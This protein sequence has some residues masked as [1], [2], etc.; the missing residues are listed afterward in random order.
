MPLEQA[1]R[2]ADHPARAAVPRR[3]VIRA[4]IGTWLGAHV[5]ASGGHARAQTQAATPSAGQAVETQPGTTIPEG[6]TLASDVAPV[7]GSP[8]RG[9]ALRLVRPGKSVE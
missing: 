9:G 1:E 6:I 5:S 7:A 4:A 8:A 2:R 3:A